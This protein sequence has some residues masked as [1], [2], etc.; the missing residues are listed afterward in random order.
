VQDRAEAT[1]RV[2]AEA[3]APLDVQ[4]VCTLG[5]EGGGRARPALPGDPIVVSHAP[6]LA[7]LQRAALCITHCGMN[8]T[9]EA[10]AAGVPLVGIPI[11]YDQ[12]AVAARIRHA[13]LGRTIP[14][15]RLDGA[16]L[17][18]A[19]EDVLGDPR[20]RERAA[21]VAAACRRSGGPDGAAA[22]IEELVLG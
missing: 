16:G 13:G 4:L 17:R 9:M 20:Y 8:T 7:L 14:H 21:E 18:A 12:P 19:V 22:A 3:C 6:Q 15:R 5:D 1:F 11:T 10:A 2:I